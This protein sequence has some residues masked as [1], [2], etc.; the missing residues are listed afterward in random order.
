MCDPCEI[1]EFLLLNNF[2]YNLLMGGNL[3]PPNLNGKGIIMLG[4]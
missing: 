4:C 2:S 1:W 3:G